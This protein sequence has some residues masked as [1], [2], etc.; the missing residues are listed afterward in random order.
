VVNLL[1]LAAGQNKRYSPDFRRLAETI[2]F[3]EFDFRIATMVALS[4]TISQTV[5]AAVSAA[6]L[7]HTSTTT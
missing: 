6:N 4:M 3:F 5:E 7:S 1:V 2:C